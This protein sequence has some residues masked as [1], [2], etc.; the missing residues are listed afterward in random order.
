[1]RPIQN[2]IRNSD[3]EIIELSDTDPSTPVK[4]MN[5]LHKAITGLYQATTKLK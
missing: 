1:M 4:L 3:P 5:P 2:L